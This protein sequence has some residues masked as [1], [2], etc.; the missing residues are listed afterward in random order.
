[1]K[2][3]LVVGAVPDAAENYFNVKAILEKLDME[4]LDSIAPVS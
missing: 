3:L 1:M 4:L 2:K